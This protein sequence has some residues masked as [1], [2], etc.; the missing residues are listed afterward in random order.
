[1]SLEQN[2]I[3]LCHGCICSECRVRDGNADV[4]EAAK[5]LKR[6]SGCYIARYCSRECQ[7]RHFK[8]HKE[9]CGYVKNLKEIIDKLEVKHPDLKDNKGQTSEH[10]LTLLSREKGIPYKNKLQK[11][12]YYFTLKKFEKGT[13]LQYLTKKM[14]LAMAIWHIAENSDQ[15]EVYVKFVE[16]A[17][18][19]M[20]QSI[21]VCEDVIYLY[22]MGLITIGKHDDAYDAIKFWIESWMKDDKKEFLETF[23]QEE[24]SSGEGKWLDL[25]KQDMK[26]NILDLQK[27]YPESEVY[28]RKLIGPFVPALIA[29]KL[30]II[31]KIQKECEEENEELKKQLKDFEVYVDCGFFQ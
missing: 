23:N 21:F 6:C 31:A 2:T 17:S 8:D 3:P 18:D 24:T 11:D 15:F 30:K 16:V 10:E 5:N 25:P 12:S 1:M 13:K 9:V 7:K 28:F 20:K 27:S 26:E 19:L 14:S 29:I 4:E 22:V